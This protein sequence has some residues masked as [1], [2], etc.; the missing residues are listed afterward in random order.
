[1]PA[2]SSPRRSPASK[3]RTDVEGLERALSSRKK[4]ELVEVLLEL[5]GDDPRLKRSLESRFSVLPQADKLVEATRQAIADATSFDPRD[6]GTNFSIDY[7]A[8]ESVQEGLERLIGAGRLGEAMEL[9]VELMKRGSYQVESSDE[10]LMT[11]E[12][13]QC[14]RPVVAAVSE[15]D[16]PPAEV[17]AWCVTMTKSDLIGVHCDREIETLRKQFAGSRPK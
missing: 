15:S 2:N 6:A 10:G 13:E 16:L 12:I 17:T 8:Y 5:A 11:E 1:M 3:S 14:L 7:D 9:A 4:T